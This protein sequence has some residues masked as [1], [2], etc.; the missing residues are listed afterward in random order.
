M[1]LRINGKLPENKLGKKYRAVFMPFCR[2]EAERSGRGKQPMSP[3]HRV[4]VFRKVIFLRPC[5][6]TL[7][8]NIVCIYARGGLQMSLELIK[9]AVRINQVI[10]QETTQTIV[11]ND[12]IVPDVKPDIA[13]ILLLDGDAFI[14]NTEIVQDKILVN[15]NIRYKIL[16]VS[17]DPEQPVKSINTSSPFSYAVDIPSA[18][19]G[20]KCRVK[21]D[22]EHMEYE[23]LNSR[24]VN[25]K[26]IVS[27]SGKVSNQL[28]QNI[29]NDFDGIEG[30]QVL[31]S[32]AS[33]NSYTGSNEVNCP[34]RETVEIPAG[35]P[36]IR[37]I[38]RNDVKITGKDY[39]LTDNK[40]VA[41]GELNVSTLYVGDDENRSIQ[42]ME[43]EIPFTQFI[44][45][46]GV[47][48]NTCC[49]VEFNIAD[50]SFEAEEDNDGELRFLRGEVMLNIFVDSFG[51]KEIELVED[52]YSPDSRISLEKDIFKTEELITENK[53][54]VIL[55]ETVE[56]SEESPDIAEVFNVLS[57]PSLSECRL[58][59]DRIMLE[60]VLESNILYLASSTEQPVFCS[61]R[62]I[63]FKHTI[64]V[65]G[66]NPDM[67]CTV[68]VN[69]EHCS[70][71]MISAREVEIRFVNSVIVRINNQVEIPVVVKAAEQPLDDKRQASR[72]SIVIYFTQPGDNLWKIAKRYYIPMDELKR[73]NNI[74]ADGDVSPGDQVIIT[75][76]IV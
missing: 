4:F 36:T 31:R 52:A 53:S 71:S 29:V 13:R 5:Q 39:K 28:E 70:Y 20:M 51:K 26:T 75:R 21:C 7:S 15:G 74:S 43:H 30:V 57:K 44:D 55:K 48:E 49:E 46:P 64:D 37:E 68:E 19:Q 38:L 1:M 60:G 61:D 41:K 62:E 10:G 33:I 17:D 69:I 35:K 59:D 65:K 24:K 11:E 54:Q 40:V 6:Y 76:K 56:I 73:V 66:V 32:T 72:P 12:I 14:G 9:E 50:L 8:D 67:N 22:I 25:V 16:Y 2:G 3:R 47:D 45:L 23:I 42:F 27:I 34:V 18:R 63:P 58:A